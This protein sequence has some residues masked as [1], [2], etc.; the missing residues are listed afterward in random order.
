MLSI[1]VDALPDHA[2]N[3]VERQFELYDIMQREVDGRALNFL[4]AKRLLAIPSL[5][6]CCL[7]PNWKT[8]P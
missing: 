8:T 6:H 1:L 2:K 5:F 7:D 4:F 3:I